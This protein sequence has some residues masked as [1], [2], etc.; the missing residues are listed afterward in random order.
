MRLP[1]R[2]A[3]LC[4]AVVAALAG[5]TTAA[6]QIPGARDI[7]R[8]AE[9]GAKRAAM[10]E[11]EQLAAEAVHCVFDNFECIRKAEE[12]GEPVVLTDREGQIL[13][14]E[15]GNPITDPSQLPGGG[16]AAGVPGPGGDRPAVPGE[17]ASTYDFQPGDRELY[18][19]DFA[20]DNLGDFPRGLEL[21]EGNLQV[22]EWQG[23][24]FL[25]TDSKYSAFAV[26]LPETLPDQFT[27]EFDL[28]DAAGHYGVGIALSDPP[29]RGFVWSAYY[30]AQ[31]LR[32]GHQHGSGV[33]TGRNNEKVSTT[34]DMSSAEGIV[35][36]RIMVD[37]A[38]AKMF[39]GEKRVANVPQADL[40]R[41][42]KVFFF[43]QSLPPDKLTYIADIRV[44]AGGRDLYDALEADGRVAIRDILFDT[45]SA[46]IRPESAP[47]LAQI[48]T[49][50]QEHPE[51]NLLVEGHTDSEGEFDWNMQLS[52][53]RAASVKA[54][55]VETFGIAAERMRTMGLGS[56]QPVETNETAEGRQKNRRVELVKI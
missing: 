25:Q 9:E 3:I 43:M 22:I 18:V 44:A 27:I 8:A 23:R 11:V 17:T 14:D 37:G 48:G 31:V 6:A 20:A 21:V 45:N 53:D 1:F 28:Y 35:P 16:A 32:A 42:D 52:A 5:P 13:T 4:A 50:M 49:M 56:T 51:L 15:A 29:N 2:L 33:W 26:P 40:P 39:I 24:R 36:V 55:L 54:Y 46:T 30:D 38:H 7:K 34:V 19:A 10:S 41:S 12:D 47:V